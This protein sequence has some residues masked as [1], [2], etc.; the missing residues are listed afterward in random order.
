MAVPFSIKAEGDGYR[1]T[2]YLRN[3][4]P[5][6]LRPAQ[7]AEFRAR[8]EEIV[9]EASKETGHIEQG[10]IRGIARSRKRSYGHVRE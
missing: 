4:Q 6:K 3:S 10:K 7:R 9:L 2:S 8:R 5:L 1:G